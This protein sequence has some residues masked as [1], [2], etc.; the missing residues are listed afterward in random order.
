MIVLTRSGKGIDIKPIHSEMARTGGLPG[1]FISY[2]DADAHTA[3]QVCGE[4]AFSLC[5][6]EPECPGAIR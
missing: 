6:G 1:F 4:I 5:N 2:K 3:Q